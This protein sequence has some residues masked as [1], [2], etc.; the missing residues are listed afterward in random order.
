MSRYV[1]QK[2]N[3]WYVARPGAAGSYTPRLSSARVYNSLSEA[4][5]DRCPEN[6]RIL[7]LHTEL[8][9]LAPRW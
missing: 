4:E 9:K 6:E 3:G 8:D 2:E 1:I 5:R 7:S